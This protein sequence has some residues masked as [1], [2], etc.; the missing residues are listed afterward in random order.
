M[1]YDTQNRILYTGVYEKVKLSPTEHQLFMCL[2]TGKL[3]TY[4]EI[5]DRLEISRNYFRNLK[6][7]FMDKLEYNVKIKSVRDT[8]MILED[9]IYYE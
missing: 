8:G 7:R 3:V 2:S 5:C 4:D 6:Q 9:E 1:T